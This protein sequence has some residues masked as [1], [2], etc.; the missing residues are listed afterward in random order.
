MIVS[1]LHL[2]LIL[3][4]TRNTAY[5]LDD[6][7]GDGHAG[8]ELD[9]EGPP[10]ERLGSSLLQVKSWQRWPNSDLLLRIHC[11][12]FILN[13]LYL[14]YWDFRRLTLSVFA[15]CVWRWTGSK[16]PH[17]QRVPVKSVPL[18]S[19]LAQ[20]SWRYVLHFLEDLLQPGFTGSRTIAT[21]QV[22]QHLGEGFGNSVFMNGI[23]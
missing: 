10:L 2:V 13:L 5:R 3:P 19:C 6:V 15:G 18:T 17:N 8:L 11:C 16:P 23:G 4:T 7:L 20:G 1:I 9:H 21:R 12:W 14:N 22:R